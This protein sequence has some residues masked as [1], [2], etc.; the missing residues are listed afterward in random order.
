MM[1]P[2]RL[3]VTMMSNWAGILDH[4]VGDVV[5][6]E[7]LRLD[8]WILGRKL[9]EDA[10]EEALAELEDIGLRGAGDLG[11]ALSPGQ[12]EGVADRSSRTRDE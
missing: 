5:D 2:A 6:D 11:A 10:L 9:L 12:L 1:S 7:V 3:V 4:L 8:L